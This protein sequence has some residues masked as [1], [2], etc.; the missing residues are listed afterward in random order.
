MFSFSEEF[1]VSTISKTSTFE[2]FWHAQNFLK[3]FSQSVPLGS[4]WRAWAMGPRLP[5]ARCTTQPTTAR[6][7]WLSGSSRPR[8]PWMPR[9]TGAVASDEGFGGK[10]LLRQWDFYVRKWMKRW[11]VDGFSVLVEIAFI[12]FWWCTRINI[13]WSFCTCDWFVSYLDGLLRNRTLELDSFLSK[14]SA[15][16]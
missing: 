12:K 2:I 4:A 7:Q 8:R 15:C 9:I 13:C 1:W 14:I 16:Q 11:S 10:T 5:E 6:S 3:V